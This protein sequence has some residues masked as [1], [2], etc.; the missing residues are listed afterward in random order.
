MF[1][2]L[3]LKALGDDEYRA[4]QS[5]LVLRPEQGAVIPGSGGLRKITMGSERP[6]KT[7]RSSSDLFLGQGTRDVLHAFLVPKE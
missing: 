7:E 5:S 1:T 2:E 3:V 6:R 4:L